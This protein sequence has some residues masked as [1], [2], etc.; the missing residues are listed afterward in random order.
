MTT[1]EQP[2]ERTDRAILDGKTEGF[3]RVVLN[4]QS[5]RILGATIVGEGAG[6][7]I[8]MVSLAMSS[9]LGLKAIGKTVMPYPTRSELLKRVADAYNRTRLTPT[10]QRWLSRWLRLTNS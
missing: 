3:I 8:S 4:G 7:L 9:R 10:T 5:D 1:I 2:F 6:D